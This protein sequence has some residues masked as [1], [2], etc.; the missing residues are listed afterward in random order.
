MQTAIKN[1]RTEVDTV[2]FFP[3]N[4]GTTYFFKK[5]TSLDFFKKNL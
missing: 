1:K 4:F 5:F 2:I 3:L